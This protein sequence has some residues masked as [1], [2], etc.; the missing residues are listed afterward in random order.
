MM[1]SRG[2]ISDRVMIAYKNHKK[3]K[4]LQRETV[5]ITGFLQRFHPVFWDFTFQTESSVVSC[6]NIIAHFRVLKQSACP[7]A[8]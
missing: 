5:S 4:S 7:I 6:R 8:N 3:S 1:D 2:A